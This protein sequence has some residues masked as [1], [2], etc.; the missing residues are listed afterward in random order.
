[1]PKNLTLNGQEVLDEYVLQ[2]LSRE[3]AYSF[4]DYSHTEEIYE[5]VKEEMSNE[6]SKDN[7][8]KLFNGNRDD[9]VKFYNHISE[10]LAM[11]LR[12]LNME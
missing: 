7:F 5:Q 4:M 8:T 1:M 3:V 9:S 6:Y 12:K 11:K 2:E 10:I